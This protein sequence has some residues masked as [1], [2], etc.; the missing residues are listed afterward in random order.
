MSSSPPPL[1]FVALAL[2]GHQLGL[3][4]DLQLFGE[5]LKP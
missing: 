3:Q 5:G 2:Q 4:L 1:E